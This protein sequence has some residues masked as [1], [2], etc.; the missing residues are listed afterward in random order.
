M[1]RA[2]IKKVGSPGLIHTTMYFV[3]S[4]LFFVIMIGAYEHTAYA[5]NSTIGALSK[6]NIN[7][8]DEWYYSKGLQTPPRNWNSLDSHAGNWLSGPTGIGYGTGLIRTH[9]ED[10]QGNYSTVYALKEFFIDNPA[11][12][13]GMT[14][15]V[16]CD[17]PFVAYLNGVEIIRTRTV[18][19]STP[20]QPI[21]VA[22][23]EQFNVS[24]FIHELNP[25]ENILALQCDNDDINSDDFSFIPVF[26]VFEKRGGQ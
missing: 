22:D 21:G 20:D 11:V 2:S 24:G 19:I 17:G 15:S 26:E 8:G 14:L 23:V 6:V 3:I 16:V 18:Q 7:D 4:I 13:S 5:Q 25:G 12:V 1:K 9:L 10:M